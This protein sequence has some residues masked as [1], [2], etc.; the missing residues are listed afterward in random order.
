MEEIG[1]E[2]VVEEKFFWPNN[3]WAKGKYFK[4]IG[5]LVCKDFLNGVEGISLKVLGHLGWT[6]EEVRD[7]VG[8][9]RKD[10]ED[11]NIHAYLRL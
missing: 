7:L 1:F 10:F 8:E 5:A 2:D 11:T 9:V 4:E 6:A 3:T